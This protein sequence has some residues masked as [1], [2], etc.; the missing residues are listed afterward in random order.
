MPSP[1][2]TTVADLKVFL[3]IAAEET[4]EDD[5]LNAMLCGVEQFVAKYL[6]RTLPSASY[7]HYFDGHG[8]RELFLNQRP[9]TAVSS[10]KIDPT[11]Y[12]GHGTDAFDSDSAIALGEDWIPER[13]DAGESNRGVLLHLGGGWPVGVQNIKVA[14]TAGY[15]AIPQDV[16]NAVHVLAA[17]VYTQAGK[18]GKLQSETLG[19]YSYSLAIGNALDGSDA[20]LATARAALAAYREIR[21]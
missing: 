8:R 2:L 1:V 11:G 6:G 12:G 10:V 5:R 19:Q 15:S 14:Y 20:E 21:W 7:T 4:S 13:S 18:G 16:I 17:E 9:V 3:G